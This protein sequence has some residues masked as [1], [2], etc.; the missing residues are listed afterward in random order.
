MQLEPSTGCLIAHSGNYYRIVD[1]QSDAPDLLMVRARVH[2]M[3][4]GHYL[5]VMHIFY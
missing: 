1:P 4:A 2:G 3:G 5:G